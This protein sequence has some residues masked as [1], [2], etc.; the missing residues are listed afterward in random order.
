MKYL[1]ECKSCK[2]NMRRIV[3]N[4]IEGIFDYIDVEDI[5]EFQEKILNSILI[6][7]DFTESDSPKSYVLT[8]EE[9]VIYDEI[10]DE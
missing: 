9:S 7:I 8:D 2:N 3:F 1:R 10:K 4:P 5:N 6:E